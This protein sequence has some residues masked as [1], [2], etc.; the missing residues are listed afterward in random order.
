MKKI[1]ILFALLFTM[2]ISVYSQTASDYYIPLCVGNYT[3][4]Y[5]PGN[6]SYGARKTVY[7]I[8]QTD[9]VAGEIAYLQEAFEIS[10]ITPNDTSIFQ[11][12][13]LREDD[14]GNILMV[15]IIVEAGGTFE[16]AFILPYP[17][18]FFPNEYLTLGY[19][20][21]YIFGNQTTYD[22]VLSISANVG[23]YSN[24]ILVRS[25]VFEDQSLKVI[26][27]YYYAPNAGLVKNER[28]F[29]S[30]D[31]QAYIASL[32][33]I[34]ASDC[35]LGLQNDEFVDENLITIYPNPA[36][37]IVNLKIQNSNNELLKLNIYNALGIL[38][39]TLSISKKENQVNVSDLTNGIYF[40]TV[41]FDN[42]TAKQKLVINK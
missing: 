9:T 34:L 21:S 18:E 19:N 3:S 11:Q 40:T 10:D 39:K 37:Y 17:H 41:S 15:A 31:P 7:H 20:R 29:H 8:K 36:S 14:N 1:I 23:T 24:C 12:F 42:F 13:W 22:T 5:T 33:D 28:L 27:D 26:D 30:P 6:D 25:T 4:L 2:I 16:D 38:V 35:N 32:T